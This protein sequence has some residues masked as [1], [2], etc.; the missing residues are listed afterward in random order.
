MKTK[1]ILAEVI[2]VTSVG[3][4]GLLVK[5]IAFESLPGPFN[6]GSVLLR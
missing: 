2:R 4:S 3:R 1:G 6:P 5:F